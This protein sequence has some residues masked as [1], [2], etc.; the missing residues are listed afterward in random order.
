MDSWSYY[1]LFR[2]N[3]N[4]N[5]I[6]NHWELELL[7]LVV[8]EEIES[9]KSNINIFLLILFPMLWN[10]I[11]YVF[12][13]KAHYKQPLAMAYSFLDEL[14]VRLN[15]SGKMESVVSSRDLKL[16]THVEKSGEELIILQL[17]SNY[18]THLF[19]NIKIV[20]YSVNLRKLKSYLVSILH[21][22]L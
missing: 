10:S 2:L 22:S 15:S 8:N 19:K 3:K 21:R 7:F 16:F 13:S 1:G 9:S 4:N 6:F 18:T 12:K 20:V 14:P 17:F 11:E 5:K